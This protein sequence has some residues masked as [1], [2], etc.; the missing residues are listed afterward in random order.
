MLG[1]FD[2]TAVGQ[3]GPK[4][5]E[6]AGLAFSAPGILTGKF[7]EKSIHLNQAGNLR[8]ETFPKGTTWF[9]MAP[10]QMSRGV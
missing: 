3:S 6:L 5:S 1:N 7:L 9:H 8:D 2:P 10:C 4:D